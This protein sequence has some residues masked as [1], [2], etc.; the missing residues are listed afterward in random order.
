M[1]H[2]TTHELFPL[3]LG[4]GGVKLVLFPATG[5]NA[6]PLGERTPSSSSVNMHTLEAPL[7]SLGNEA[8]V[9]VV[10]VDSDGVVT[11]EFAEIDE[12]ADDHEAYVNSIALHPTV[13]GQLIPLY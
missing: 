3:F 11:H 6:I 5:F 8:P 7:A 12:V 1:V 13:E 9:Y 10:S 2:P 4:R